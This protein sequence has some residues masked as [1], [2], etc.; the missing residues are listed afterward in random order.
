MVSSKQV[1]DGVRAAVVIVG[2]AWL[3]A[4]AISVFFAVLALIIWLAFGVE[5]G[6][7]DGSGQ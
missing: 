3:G 2:V 7:G 6:P 4:F 5:L 1:K